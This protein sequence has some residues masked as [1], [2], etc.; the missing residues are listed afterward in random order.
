MY[1]VFYRKQNNLVL[2]INEE[3]EGIGLGRKKYD[4]SPINS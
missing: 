4:N 3:R 1:D 2:L